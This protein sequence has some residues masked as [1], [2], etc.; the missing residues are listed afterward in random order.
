MS[1][2]PSE[3]TPRAP[4]TGHEPGVSADPTAAPV[5]AVAPFD[6][7]RFGAPDHPVPPEYAPPGYLPPPPTQPMPQPGQPPYGGYQY[8]QS[9]P[10]YPYGGQ[11]YGPPPPWT[12]QY[13][14]PRTGNGK[15]ITALV[16]G[17]L[18]VLF[19]WTTVL[20]IVPVALAI[21]FGIIAMNDAK[22]TGQP[23]RGMATWGLVLGVIGAL[24]A[25]VTTVVIYTRVK[26]CIDNYASG[27]S[28]YNSCIHDR[29]HF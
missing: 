21:I 24:V 3:P 4:E 23:G 2:P 29:L 27:S 10:Q 7:Y 25:T 17:I 28:E 9:A 5:Q 19:F 18:S 11:Y 1:T 12:T 14:P 6:P 16:F 20:D 22:R 13:P 26:P 8:P 15:A